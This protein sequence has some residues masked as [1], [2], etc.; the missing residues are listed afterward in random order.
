MLQA[1]PN[2]WEDLTNGKAHESTHGNLRI[3][4]EIKIAPKD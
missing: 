2:P 4:V 3:S 1:F